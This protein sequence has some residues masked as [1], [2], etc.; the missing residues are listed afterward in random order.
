MFTEELLHP[1]GVSG[2]GLRVDGTLYCLKKSCMSPG[3]PLQSL[4]V[5]V[6]NVTWQLRDQMLSGSRA[7]RRAMGSRN[8]DSD[9]IVQCEHILLCVYRC[10]NVIQCVVSFRCGKSALKT[11]AD[12][13]N[14]LFW[15]AAGMLTTSRLPGTAER[16]MQMSAARKLE[17]F[18]VANKQNQTCKGATTHV[19]A[20]LRNFAA[21]R[22]LPKMKPEQHDLRLQ[23]AMM[24]GFNKITQ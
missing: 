14:S 9:G 16:T 6:P 11:T 17:L 8:T 21:W 5:R 22:F 18:H 19:S 23:Q 3:K 15:L 4:S 7:G 12:T 13:S 20:A 10:E 1:S 2:C 24:N